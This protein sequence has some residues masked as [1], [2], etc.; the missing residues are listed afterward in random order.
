[1]I[2][3]TDWVGIYLPSDYRFPAETVKSPGFNIEPQTIHLPLEGRKT[4]LT[5]FSVRIV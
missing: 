3:V 4:S 2:V 5:D 1:M